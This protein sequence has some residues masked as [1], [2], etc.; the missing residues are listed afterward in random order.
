MRLRP[1]EQTLQAFSLSRGRHRIRER[2]VFL[3][4]IYAEICPSLPTERRN[5]VDRPGKQSPG[6]GVGHPR[7]SR[8]L[9]FPGT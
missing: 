7:F 4:K 2:Q 6:R 3:L 1:G 8:A 9:P 5:S